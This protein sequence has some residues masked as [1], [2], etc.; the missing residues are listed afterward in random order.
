M[1]KYPITWVDYR[2]PNTD[3]QFSVAV[4]GKS[5]M[6]CHMFLGD[7]VL[8]RSFIRQVTVEGQS[9][10][11]GQHCLAMDCPLNQTPKEHLVHMLDM[12]EDEALDE[13]TAKLWGTDS[14]AEGLVKFAEKMNESIPEELKKGMPAEE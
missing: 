8:R 2:L 4:C 7:D 9:C 13:E 6:V 5:G 1:P 10:S 14:M 11:G 3:R 12:H